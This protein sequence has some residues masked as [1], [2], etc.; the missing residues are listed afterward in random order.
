MS[1]LLVGLGIVGM[2]WGVA[3]W[4]GLLPAV[5][6]RGLTGGVHPDMVASGLGLVLIGFGT[7]ASVRA[8]GFV[9]AAL[10]LAGSALW[11]LAPSWL[12][13]AWYK[14]RFPKP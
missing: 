3:S 10:I 1:L 4:T 11:V 2:A 13:P 9:G 7:Y 12:E 8:L 5:R 14:R 6:R